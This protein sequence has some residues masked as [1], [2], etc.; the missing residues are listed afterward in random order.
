M[1]HLHTIQAN[2]VLEQP[3][4]QDASVFEVVQHQLRELYPQAEDR[5]VNSV[6]KRAGDFVEEYF[7]QPAR[8]DEIGRVVLLGSAV[9]VTLQG[10]KTLFGKYKQGIV[11][12]GTAPTIFWD[13]R[14]TP[15]EFESL[16]YNN[17][18]AET[19]EANEPTGSTM[20]EIMYSYAKKNDAKIVAKVQEITKRLTALGGIFEGKQPELTNV[21]TLP[22]HPER[23][24]LLQ[25]E[26]RAAGIYKNVDTS[27]Y[28]SRSKEIV[29]GVSTSNAIT[30]QTALAHS[31]YGTLAH[32]L[33]HAF[34]AKKD[35][36]KIVGAQDA[37]FVVTELL[38]EHVRIVA[39]YTGEGSYP[40]ERRLQYRLNAAAR[41]DIVQDALIEAA[42]H[43]E[44]LKAYAKKLIHV[45]GIVLAGLVLGAA[46]KNYRIQTNANFALHDISL[47]GQLEEPGRYAVLK[48]YVPQHVAKALSSDVT[49]KE[50]W[51][52]A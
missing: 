40:A 23:C 31:A 29:L 5:Y 45:G 9:A 3:H 30:H 13:T 17:T 43:D 35:T 28:F 32:E 26:L 2:G 50:K 4:M 27:W 1:N 42:S 34:M 15:Y 38:A 6:V 24:M 49:I 39:G 46:P 22:L 52:A 51:H 47:L 7:E 48:Q 18:R 12:R 11:P 19:E 21:Y 20:Q 8:T 25:A 10:H 16:L 36:Y 33:G 44:F 37:A 41:T 14:T